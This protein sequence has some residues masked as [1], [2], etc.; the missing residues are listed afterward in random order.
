MGKVENQLYDQFALKVVHK[1][2]TRQLPQASKIPT[3]ERMSYAANANKTPAADN[4]YSTL[5]AYPVWFLGDPAEAYQ[6]SVSK[7][8]SCTA[9]V[10]NTPAAVN[11][12]SKLWAYPEWCLGNP[13]EAYHIPMRKQ[14][15][16]EAS[17]NNARHKLIHDNHIP[18]QAFVN[19]LENMK[20][21]QPTPG[22]TSLTFKNI[23]R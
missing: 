21:R 10:N 13:A 6:H 2:T 20:Q 15:P 18:A 4:R 5:R 7:Q 17:D 14:I 23:H 16:F 11:R 8:Q 22:E 9:N 1:L 12:C 19:I 3:S